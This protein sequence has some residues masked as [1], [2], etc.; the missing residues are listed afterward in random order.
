MAGSPG[1]D[2]QGSH[3]SLPSQPNSTRGIHSSVALF[4]CWSHTVQPLAHP[5]ESYDP[6]QT[7]SSPTPTLCPGEIKTQ[8]RTMT[9]S[10]PTDS[11]P[12]QNWHLTWYPILHAIRK[13]P[14]SF[15]LYIKPRGRKFTDPRKVIQMVNRRGLYPLEPHPR[16]GSSSH[17]VHS[18]GVFSQ[19]DVRRDFCSTLPKYD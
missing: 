4:F 5:L 11:V 17:M 6:E 8:K 2:L 10:G 18:P 16:L 7:L 14:L 15:S 19:A 12:T 13:E 1:S 3:K 9:T